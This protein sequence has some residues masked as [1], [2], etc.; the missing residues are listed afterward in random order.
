MQPRNN[1]RLHCNDKQHVRD[2]ALRVFIPPERHA[3]AHSGCINF[4]FVPVSVG[5]PPTNRNSSDR[6]SM[7]AMWW[8]QHARNC[9]AC[10]S[11][12]A[13]V[14]V[15]SGV[16][17]PEAQLSCSQPSRRR[18]R[19]GGEHRPCGAIFASRRYR[20]QHQHERHTEQL[21]GVEGAGAPVPVR[22]ELPSPPPQPARAR[23]HP[24]IFHIILVKLFFI[25]V[26]SSNQFPILL[27]GLRRKTIA[28][29]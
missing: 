4:A 14:V 13:S 20:G 12:A 3:G 16:C 26:L 2:R 27:E 11:P 9:S 15:S 6:W 25:A 7:D 17:T 29:A 19:G 22:T 24:R 1:C 5:S 10:A 8:L 18:R 23:L 28:C 21:L